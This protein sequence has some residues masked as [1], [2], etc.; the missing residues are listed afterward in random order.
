MTSWCN[1]LNW[2]HNY[3]SR[4][5]SL[6]PIQLFS[7]ECRD[8]YLIVRAVNI[9][10]LNL[11]CNLVLLQ[12]ILDMPSQTSCMLCMSECMVSPASSCLSVYRPAHTSGGSP[13]ASEPIKNSSVARWCFLNQFC[14]ILQMHSASMRERATW[15]STKLLCVL[16]A[17]VKLVMALTAIMCSI[18]CMWKLKTKIFLV[19]LIMLSY[20]K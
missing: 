10:Q 19:L 11:T 20:N 15:K 12:L 6:Q 14:V 18:F 4:A 7:I 1:L 8:P 9:Y 3:I 2:H 13:K 5:P 17:C 16:E